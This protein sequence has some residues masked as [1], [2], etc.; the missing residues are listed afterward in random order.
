MKYKKILDDQTIIYFTEKGDLYIVE[1]GKEDSLREK[2][3]RENLNFEYKEIQTPTKLKKL[4]I[5]L[6]S[7]C[8]LRCRYCYLDYGKH[9]NEDYIHNIDIKDAK[10][11]IDLILEKYPEGIG[12]IQFFGGEPLLAFNE[13]KNICEYVKILFS[14]K[15]LK[16]PEFGVV[17]N[18]ILL[19]EKVISY[20]ND[21]MIRTTISIDGDQEAH[22]NVRIRGDGSGAY[23]DIV[24]KLKNYSSIIKF[25]LFYEVTLNREHV[26]LYK[27][28][29]VREWLDAIKK[30]GF[31][32][33]IMGIVEFS[34]DSMLDIKEEDIPILEKI[35]KEFVEYYFDVM[36]MENSDFYN[37]DIM[38]LTLLLIGKKFERYNCMTGISQL[39]LAANGTFYPCPKF[40]NLGF[41]LGSVD[42]QNIDNSSM[43]NML[44]EDLREECLKC[45]LQNIC[46]TYCIA[47]KYRN[48]NNK[49]DVY[50][51]CLHMKL[52]MENVIINVVKL[53]KTGD[54]NRIVKKMQ[55]QI[56][57]IV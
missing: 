49:Q 25:P 19:N 12:F 47:H 45:W 20:F 51:R 1:K 6:T 30:L 57:K 43:K 4:I 39:T 16:I 44:R 24:E 14:S 56:K 27:E 55:N 54:L 9:K 23:S 28:G 11:A 32:I 21:N 38:K 17:T 34:K 37:L 7:A 40:A 36:L 33:G 2:I 42:E 29:K 50:T 52:L 8:N 15:S 53:Y 41:K 31:H 46:S 26:L 10:K 48:E 35:Y 18:G 22:D 5:L 3:C 13:L